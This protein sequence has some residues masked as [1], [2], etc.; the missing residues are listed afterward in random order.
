MGLSSIT[1]SPLQAFV[2]DPCSL[3]VVRLLP[4]VTINSSSFFFYY[5]PRCVIMHSGT[6]GG[7]VLLRQCLQSW[8]F[9]SPFPGLARGLGPTRQKRGKD[10]CVRFRDTH[11]VGVVTTTPE[12]PSARERERERCGSEEDRTSHLKETEATSPTCCCL[13]I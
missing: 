11:M 4:R 12:F 8:T 2:V 1:G 13:G 3:S 7:Y 6:H 10:P 9:P 5:W